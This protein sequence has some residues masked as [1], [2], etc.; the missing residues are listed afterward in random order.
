MDVVSI[1]SG[2]VVEG[3]GCLLGARCHCR[4]HCRLAEQQP[5][6]C[7]GRCWWLL[8]PA[9]LRWRGGLGLVEP[10]WVTELLV[11]SGLV[12]T[13]PSWYL[14]FGTCGCT[15]RQLLH[16]LTSCWGFYLGSGFLVWTYR[17]FLQSLQ[18]RGAP[19]YLS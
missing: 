17:D 4:C 6:A 13:R 9:G 7:P 19:R 5:S 14:A 10:H 3:A 11:A 15:S 16:R 2:G 12:V 8:A 1:N 18:G